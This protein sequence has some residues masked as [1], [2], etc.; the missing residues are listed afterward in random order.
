MKM[1]IK[2]I[3]FRNTYLNDREVK[4]LIILLSLFAA[5]MILGAGMWRTDNQNA[6]IMNNLFNELI[7]YRNNLSF[8]DIFCNSFIFNFAV[9]F[10][11]IFFG[12]SPIGSVFV[13]TIPLIRGM[14]YGILSGY[15]YSL[16]KLQGVGYYLLTVFPSALLINIFII[17]ASN[18]A[19]FLSVDI[20]SVIMKKMNSDKLQVNKNLKINIVCIVICVISAIFQSVTIK[21]FSY[22]FQF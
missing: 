18:N 1:K 2:A 13:S 17:I 16:H 11:V 20:L 15:L 12:Y 4:G 19:C 6:T 7:N 8:F 5:G 9:M 10:L 22:L 21:T 3:N 14:C